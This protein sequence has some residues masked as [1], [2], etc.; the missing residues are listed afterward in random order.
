MDSRNQPARPRFSA[1]SLKPAIFLAAA[2]AI[3]IALFSLV[4]ISRLTET[5][6][7]ARPAPL[8]AAALLQVLSP[9]LRAARLR[10]ILGGTPSLTR[11]FHIANTGNMVNSLAPLRAGEFCMTFLLSGDLRG[12]AGEALSKIFVDRVLDV[13]TVALVFIISALFLPGDMA[14]ASGLRGAAAVC[15]A[16]LPAAWLLLFLLSR[17]QNPTL[18]LLKLLVS[19]L[20]FLSW[21]SLESKLRSAL[22]GLDILFRPRALLPLLGWS[23]IIWTVIAASYHFGMAAL[24]PPPSPWAPVLAMCFTVVGLMTVAA[25][26][27]IGA[28]HGAIV[29]ALSLFGAPVDQGLAFALLYHAMVV[30]LNVALGLIGA[31]CLGFRPGRLLRLSAR[32][33]ADAP[34]QAGPR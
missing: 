5:L 17:F 7:R 27:G 25:P 6:S 20:R 16:A 15:A 10:R 34:E 29:I 30:V 32:R 19:P 12:G 18:R 33:G 21:D 9:L 31:K 22:N 24:F 26:A 1:A 11:V 28:T 3:V 2:C 23:V 14:A 4:D 8:L 13:V